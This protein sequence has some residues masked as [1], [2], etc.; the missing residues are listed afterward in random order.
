MFFVVVVFGV[1]FAFSKCL[2]FC[3]C[4][5]GFFCFV[6]LS[7]CLIFVF[8]YL[9]RYSFFSFFPFCHYTLK[10]YFIQ[11]TVSLGVNL[12]GQKRNIIASLS[13]LLFF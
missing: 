3:F 10:N 2:L 1:V 8:F 5:L 4:F 13:L 12:D 11:S 7:V 9:F 6:F